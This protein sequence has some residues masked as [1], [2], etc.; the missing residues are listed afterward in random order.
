M[1]REVVDV[2]FEYVVFLDPSQRI[3]FIGRKKTGQAEGVG[4]FERAL[5]DNKRLDR[6]MTKEEWEE[7]SDALFKKIRVQDWEK[8]YEPEGVCVSDGYQWS[9]RITLADRT[10][11]ETVGK[12]EVPEN[13]EE[14]MDLLQP[15]FDE[16][17][18]LPTPEPKEEKAPEQEGEKDPGPEE[19]AE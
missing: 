6:K 3:S 16:Y 13:W 17:E 10:K 14:L 2:Y 11:Y 15:F 4:F 7:M 18:A 5:A 19:K 12:N 1:A 8:L 9:L